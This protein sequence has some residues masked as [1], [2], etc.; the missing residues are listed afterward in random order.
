MSPRLGNSTARVRSPCKDRTGAPRRVPPTSTA[1]RNSSGSRANCH[2]ASLLSGSVGIKSSMAAYHPTHGTGC[3]RNG[4]R[5]RDGAQDQAAAGLRH[6]KVGGVYV[7]Y[8]QK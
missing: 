7:V 2:G 8:V 6:T 1:P 4:S 3:G 5:P